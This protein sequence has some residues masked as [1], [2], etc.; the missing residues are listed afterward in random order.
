M[1]NGVLTRVGEKFTTFPNTTITS[2]QF[3]MY[4]EGG[5]PTGTIT[6]NVRNANTDVVIGTLGTMSAHHL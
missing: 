1:T 6:C 3:N 2:I 4:I 5:S